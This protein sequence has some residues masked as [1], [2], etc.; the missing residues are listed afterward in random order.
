MGV[1][2]TMST[3]LK[4]PVADPRPKVGFREAAFIAAFGELIEQGRED[5]ALKYLIDQTPH[6]L[7][8][9]L[10]FREKHNHLLFMSRMIQSFGNS[11][12]GYEKLLRKAGATNKAIDGLPI[13]KG[14][15]FLDFGCGAHDPIALASYYY[16]NGFERAVACDLLKP[17]NPAYSAMAMYDILADI[18]LKPKRY[19]RPEADPELFRRRIEEFDFEAFASGDFY[20]GFGGMKGKIDYEIKNLVELPI[21][22]GELGYVVS[23][24]VFEH[25]DH[26]EEVNTWLF[27]RTT[28]GGLHYHFIDMADHRF[29]TPGSGFNEFSFMAEETGP[30][31][32]NRVRASEHLKAFERAGFEVVR[33]TTT[34]AVM[35]PETKAALLPKFAAMTEADQNTTKLHV[36]LRKPT[37]TKARKRA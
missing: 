7:A 12:H 21:E 31:N 29:Y 22:S 1:N 8:S 13:P 18:A 4:D 3:A 33:T 2:R 6:L 26:L 5:V 24:A 25:V 36:T 20:G 27:D 14:K 30:S 9:R 28:P 15:T 23:F 32:L 16:C 37:A 11:K 10:N 17:R 34:E 35:P 19:L